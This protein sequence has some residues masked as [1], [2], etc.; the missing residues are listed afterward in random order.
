MSS[1]S[2]HAVEVVCSGEGSLGGLR[3]VED[4]LSLC[5]RKGVPTIWVGFVYFCV[6]LQVMDTF[7]I[8]KA[9]PVFLNGHQKLQ[10]GQILSCRG[11]SWLSFSSS[12]LMTF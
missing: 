9:L 5:S 7:K 3:Q 10:M 8:L 2:A 1:D 4:A 12:V 11:T 6:L